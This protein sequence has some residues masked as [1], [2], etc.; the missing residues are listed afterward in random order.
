[1]AK[2]EKQ[3]T[4]NDVGLTKTH[5]AG[6]H[7]P[8]GAKELLSTLPALNP[9]IRNPDTWFDC[10][11][12]HGLVWRFRYIY[13]NSKL[14]GDGTRDEYRL[15]QINPFLKHNK[16]KEGDFLTIELK[17]EKYFVGIRKDSDEVSQI[18]DKNYVPPPKI[19]LK[20]WREVH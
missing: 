8:K 18:L 12:E 9:R 1:M 4:A 11:D 19:K 13:Y 5:Q 3:L 15:L 7:I 16:A 20:G 10:M 14:F 17:S 2:F 6:I